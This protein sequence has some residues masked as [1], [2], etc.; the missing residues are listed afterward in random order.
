MA[1][2][3]GRRYVTALIT[4]DAEALPVYAARL[5]L[6]GRVPE[7]LAGSAEIRGE[8]QAAIDRANARL[9]S[10]EQI[11]RFTVLPTAWLPDTDVLTPTAKLKRRVI[12]A[13]YADDIAAMYAG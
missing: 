2:G 10:N 3:D 6:E 5:G 13:K 8:L 7:E 9:N 12:N 1:I 11:K 4:L